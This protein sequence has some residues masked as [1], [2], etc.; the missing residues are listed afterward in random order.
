VYL[1]LSQLL[2]LSA[3]TAALA[4]ILGMLLLAGFIGVFFVARHM[5]EDAVACLHVRRLLRPGQ[6]I[7]I[8]QTSGSVSGFTLTGVVIAT[9]GGQT[10]V[11]AVDFFRTSYSVDSAHG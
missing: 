8:G 11:P 1:A 9:S 3:I 7:S 2:D 4:E 5:L 6:R 10:V